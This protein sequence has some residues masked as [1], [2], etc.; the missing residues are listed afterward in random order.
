M[1]ELKVEAVCSSEMLITT[2][3]TTLHHNPEDHDQHQSTA[4]PNYMNTR[5]KLSKMCW[6]Q[7][8]SAVI[9]IVVIFKLQ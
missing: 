7:R 6:K 1:V 5:H 8:H 2:H 9:C 3:K 4:C